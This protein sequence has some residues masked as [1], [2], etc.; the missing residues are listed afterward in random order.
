MIKTHK[1]LWFSIF[2][3][4]QVIYSIEKVNPE[5][6]QHGYTY[7]VDPSVPLNT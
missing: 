5:L 2:G 1:E 3:F 6:Q 4:V 7:F